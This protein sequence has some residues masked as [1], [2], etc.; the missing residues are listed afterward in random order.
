MRGH[1]EIRKA[2]KE[3]RCSEWSHHVIGIGD[4]Y[5]SGACPPEHEMNRDGRKW[6]IIRA[7]IRCAKEYGMLCSKTREQLESWT[8]EPIHG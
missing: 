5:L 4:L 6:W 2:A 1:Y 3:H 8:R 7:C